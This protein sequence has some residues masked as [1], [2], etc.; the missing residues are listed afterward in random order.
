[1]LWAWLDAN[2]DNAEAL[3]EHPAA[4]PRLALL[5]SPATLPAFR[6]EDPEEAQYRDGRDVRQEIV[7]AAVGMWW[8]CSSRVSRATVERAIAAGVADAVG[9]LLSAPPP[10]VPEAPAEQQQAAKVRYCASG[11]L[12]A[13]FVVAPE[14]MAGVWGRFRGVAVEF[15]RRSMECL[16]AGTDRR[17]KVDRLAGPPPLPCRGGE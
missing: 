7:H 16:I 5:L 10:S 13:W 15:V 8:G 3:T 4:L 2:P 14:A 12:A 17:A 9:A 6:E 1:M 11:A